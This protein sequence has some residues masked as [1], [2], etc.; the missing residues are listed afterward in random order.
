MWS[1]VFGKV[2]ENGF[3]GYSL[4]ESFFFP[5]KQVAFSALYREKPSSVKGKRSQHPFGSV[6]GEVGSEMQWVF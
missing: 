6:S 4:L 1:F 5:P 2:F 3:I